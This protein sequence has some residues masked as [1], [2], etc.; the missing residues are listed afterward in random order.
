MPSVGS[1]RITGPAWHLR[2]QLEGDSRGEG[3]GEG[4]ARH[5][6]RVNQILCIYGLGEEVLYIFFL[7]VCFTSSYTQSWGS[8]LPSIV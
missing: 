1:C 3:L 6:Y 2:R 5:R 7:I 4:K 8:V